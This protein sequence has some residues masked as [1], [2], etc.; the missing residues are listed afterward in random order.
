MK[1]TRPSSRHP[2]GSLLNPATRYVPAAATDLRARF[3]QERRALGLPRPKPAPQPARLA[4]ASWCRR[5]GKATLL[6]ALKGA[7]P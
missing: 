7:Q 1:P 4:I 6:Q 5:H 2:A 3:A